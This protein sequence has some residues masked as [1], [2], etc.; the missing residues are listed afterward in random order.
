MKETIESHQLQIMNDILNYSSN[1]IDMMLKAIQK[2][3]IAQ[4]YNISPELIL[5][6]IWHRLLCDS[7]YNIDNREDIDELIQTLKDIFTRIPDLNAQ[8][9]YCAVLVGKRNAEGLL[10]L[11]WSDYNN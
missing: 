8:L 9:N 2:T 7:T 5:T 10:A 4:R 6:F 3:Y 11:V 1:E